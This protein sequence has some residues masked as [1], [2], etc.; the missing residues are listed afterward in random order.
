MFRELSIWRGGSQPCHLPHESALM[1]LLAGTKAKHWW[2]FHLQS[3][4]AAAREKKE[5]VISDSCLCGFWT[6]PRG[7][8][9]WFLNMKSSSKQETREPRWWYNKNSN[10][11]A[12]S[13]TLNENLVAITMFFPEFKASGTTVKK[14]QFHFNVRHSAKVPKYP[15]LH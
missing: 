6:F 5:Y 8:D 11:T 13:L 15:S 9:L 1:F 10:P 14:I 12:A 4:P 2:Q 3:N 7:K